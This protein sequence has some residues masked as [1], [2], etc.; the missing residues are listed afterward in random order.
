VEIEWP[1]DREEVEEDP[2]FMKMWDELGGNKL[3][4]GKGKEVSKK[5]VKVEIEANERD[6]V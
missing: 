3:A 2:A 1:D 4:K 5:T 6:N